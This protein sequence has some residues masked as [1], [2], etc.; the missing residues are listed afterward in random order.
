LSLVAGFFTA[1]ASDRTLTAGAYLAGAAEL[2]LAVGA[3]AFGAYRLRGLLLPGWSGAPA[4]LAEVV[5]GVAGLIWVSEAL[6]TFGGF[7]EAAVLAATIVVGLAAGLI[8]SWIAASR[9]V[10]PATR[11]PA[12]ASWSLAKV[13]AVLAC[14]AVAAGWMVPTLGT[15]AA[16][17]DRS[18]SLW[19]HM[20]LAARFVQTGYLGHIYFFDPVFLASFYPA[21]SE[22]V[23]AVPILFF[24]RDIVSPMLNLAWLTVGLLGAW[25]IGRPYGLGPQ[26]LVGASIALGSQSLVEFQAGEALNDITGVAFVLAAA[27]LLVNGYAARRAGVDPGLERR[28]AGPRPLRPTR[29]QPTRV[30]AQSGGRATGNPVPSSVAVIVPVAPVTGRKISGG[31]L[32]VAGIAAGLAAGIKL[33]FL[34]PVAA[35]TVGV[36]A[37]APRTTRLRAAALWIVP[38]LAAGGYWYVR[39]LVAVGNP[40]PYISSVG[41]ISLP[42]PTRDFH[43]RPD[44]AVVHYWNDTGVWRHWFFPGLHESF[45]TLWP[46]TLVGMVAVAVFALWRGREPILRVLGAF[47]L[48]TA[49]AYVFTPLTAAGEQGQPISFVWNVRY[50]APAVAVGL[51][52][53]PCLPALRAT[54]ARRGAVLAGLSVV[55]ALTIGS[56]VQWKQGHTKG[57]IGAA[58]LV[59]LV[60]GLIAFLRSRGML[61]RSTRLGVRVAIAGAVLALAVAA[62]YGEE[63]HYL[64]HRYEKTGQIQDLA[65]A[66]RW[67]RDIRDAR[68]AVA[69]IRGVFTQYPFYGTDLSNQVQWLGVRGPH[70]GYERI[71]N[72]RE[73]RRAIDAGGFTHVVTTFDPYLPGTLRNSPEG[74][75]TQSD[76]NAHVVLRD[77]PVRVF[78]LRGPLDPAGCTGQKPLTQAQLHSVPNLNGTPNGSQ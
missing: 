40:I 23:H 61:G 62:G 46:A 34:A 26:A 47:V 65:G 75:W 55:L 18:D 32:V 51:A 52:L 77:G 44:F 14:A 41:P 27:G 68:I 4:R 50:L 12:P 72:C 7:T 9:P 73:W 5:L 2:S 56:L 76:P 1:P 19:Y 8:A 66:L 24:H 11:P 20:P 17:M 16:G 25:C 3:L 54:P 35:L 70:D 21:N 45:G 69:G 39:N 37:I 67:S 71:P 78:E 15:L 58:V 30:S 38:T 59:L 64:T 10:A 13:V 53:L 6:G 22:V 43:L 48:V 49:V 31:A 63:R 28:S 36:I 57:A 33:S 29:L 42:A 74:R 60:A